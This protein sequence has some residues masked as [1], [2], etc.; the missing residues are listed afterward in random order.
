MTATLDAIAAPR[1]APPEDP[2]AAPRRSLP[3]TPR[4]GGSDPD[5]PT[6][7]HAIV[8]FDPISDRVEH[9]EMVLTRGGDGRRVVGALAARRP[10]A[11][12][13]ARPRVGPPSG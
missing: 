1:R 2:I 9:S 11:V 3:K 6:D 8:T 12:G 13:L 10:R 5:P 4:R 7:L